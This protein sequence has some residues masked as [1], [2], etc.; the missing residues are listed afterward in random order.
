M[1][2]ER[3]SILL[4]VHNEKMNLENV[5]TTWYAALNKIPNCELNFILCE[6]GS[7]D[8]TKELIIKLMTTFPIINLSASHRRGYG[9]ALMD[10]I[11]AAQSDYLLCIDSDG[12]CHP[13]N[14]HEFWTNRNNADFIMGR[15]Y[16]RADPVIRI[17]YSKLFLL[18]H[19]FLFRSN[20]HDPSCP[21]VLGRRAAFLSIKPYLGFLKEGFW[22]GF[23]GACC[24]HKK[25]ILEIKIHHTKRANGSTQVYQLRKMPGIVIRNLIGLLKLKFINLK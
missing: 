5:I 4:P 22:W 23:V 19:F 12:Q 16:P 3:L 2:K 9:R 25:T 18:T 6:D 7:T 13:D 14:F 24:K 15:R 21:Y 17:I 20:L 8:G 1:Q 11:D 10:G